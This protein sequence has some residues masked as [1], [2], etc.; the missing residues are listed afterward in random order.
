LPDG[1]VEA[2]NAL[3]LLVDDRVH[4]H[5]RLAHLSIADDELAL[6]TADGNHR[7]DGLDPG[8]ERLLHGLAGDDAGRLELDAA[9]VRGLDG[10][11]AVDRLAEGVHD[12][13]GG[14]FADGHLHDAAGALHERALFDRARVAE[15]GRSDV[16]RLEVQHEPHEAARKLQQLARHRP[17]EP[18]DARDAVAHA[19]DRT[20]LHRERGLLVALDLLLDDLGDLFG[21]KLHRG[22][23][24]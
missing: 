18:V 7:V 17:L 20:G 13:T 9:P 1:H 15:K 22:S 2:I 14:G 16:V 12:A 5:S 8:L 23:V 11:L 3:A 24:L 6:S 19:E 4:G 21:A 10:A